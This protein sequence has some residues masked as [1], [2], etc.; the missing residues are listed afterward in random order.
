M[1]ILST[2]TI[3]LFKKIYTKNQQKELSG[4]LLKKNGL[5]EIDVSSII[6]GN[7]DNVILVGGLYNFHTHPVKTYKKYKVIFAWPSNTDY[8]GFLLSFIVYSTILHIVVTFEGL[9]FVTL[10]D[11]WKNK[12]NKNNINNILDFVHKNHN[13]EFSKHYTIDF[14]LQEI[15][16]ILY[17]EYPIFKVFF[18]KWNL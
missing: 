14:Y 17:E 3:V 6:S 13:I 8:I 4:T 16:F 5:L 12:I 1:N 18:S 7:E 9:Y 10:T 11:Y 15:N 2:N